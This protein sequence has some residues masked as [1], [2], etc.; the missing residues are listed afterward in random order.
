M[1]SLIFFSPFPT[2]YRDNHDIDLISHRSPSYSF[3]FFNILFSSQ[4][5]L[6]LDC[7]F[8]W[9]CAF[10]W[11]RSFLFWQAHRRI[12]GSGFVRPVPHTSGPPPTPL[13][14]HT[15]HRTNCLLFALKSHTHDFSLI[16]RQDCQEFEWLGSVLLA[17]SASTNYFFSKSWIFGQLH[18]LSYQVTEWALEAGHAPRFLHLPPTCS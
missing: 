6:R 1:N 12:P 16:E 7:N 14:Q 4:H 15:P 2:Y 11:P 18:H 10:L 13:Y 17:S 9:P 3:M 5:Y 8:Y